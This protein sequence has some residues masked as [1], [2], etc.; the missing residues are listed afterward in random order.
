M[1]YP[2]QAFVLT[3]DG[4]ICVGNAHI[5]RVFSVAEGGELRTESICNRRTETPIELAFQPCSE[6]FVIRIL[7][8][9]KKTA[10]LKASMLTVSDILSTETDG[11]KILE[12]RFAPLH[13][14]GVT[15]LVSECIEVRES[16]PFLYKYLKISASDAQVVIDSIDTEHISLPRNLQQ[17]W[18]RPD[19][20]KA[21][22]SPF[23]AALGQPIYLNGMYTGSEFPAND[24]NIE[25]GIAHVRYYAGKTLS[26]LAKG[27]KEYVTWKT[28]FGAARGLE[29]EVIRA[30]FLDYIRSISRPLYLR[31]QYNS[32]FDHMLDIDKDNIRNSFFEIEKG[33]TQNGVPPVHSYV[34]DDGW[35][36]YDKDFWCFNKKFPNELYESAALAKNFSS[37]FGLWLGP[38]GGY[39]PK[40]PKF[41][42]RM[43]K[44]GKGGCNRRSRDVCT[45][46]HDY[47][48]NITELFLDYMERFDINYWKLDGF[49]LKSC[50]SKHHGHPTGGY[51]GM[52]C[53]TDHWEHWIGIFQKMRDAR[54]AMGKSL[55][56]N[57]T[58]F[59]NA[60]PW[61]LQFCESLWMQNS[62]DIDFVDKTKSGEPMHG[63]D[64]DK[65]LT[66]RDGRYFDFHRTRA[67]QFPL[68]NMYNH[69]PIYGNTA[70]ISMTDDEYRQY[71]YMIATRGTAFW[72]LYYSFSLFN[73][74]KWQINADVLKF[75]AKNFHILRNARL[76]GESP[77]TGAV[78]GY[79]GW[80]GAEGI[81]SVRNPLDRPQNFSFVLDRCIG[82][83]EGASALTCAVILPYTAGLDPKAYAYGDTVTVDLQPHEIRIFKFGMA[84]THAP[85]IIRAKMLNATTAQV[86]FDKRIAVKENSF[87]VNDIALSAELLPN[88]SEVRVSLQKPLT[89]GEEIKLTA[90][91]SD[92]YGNEMTETVMLLYHE[93]GKMA[94]VYTGNSDFTLRIKLIDAPQDGILFTQGKD[95]VVSVSNGKLI[96]DCMGV[97]AK[98]DQALR[99]HSAVRADIVRERNGMVKVYVDGTLT[100]SGYD[101]KRI[102]APLAAEDVQTGAAVHEFA[103]FDTALAFDALK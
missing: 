77:E 47:Q 1:K 61:Y 45:A 83:D 34:V 82:V 62:G 69:E 70:N 27:A 8:G 98:S 56:L 71:M 95:L 92:I 16:D 18:S 79:S 19:M 72:E 44:A 31:T 58:S 42:K 65:M 91:V 102:C 39:N 87:T 26:E 41:A 99:T 55:W 101:A 78:Y 59:C 49:L 88:Y 74:A 60:S 37:D 35:P 32:W 7:V 30:D 46:D 24:N 43:Q 4:K 64:F 33:L 67:Y 23:Q 28:V 85:K 15:Y 38:R 29:Q 17:K 36:D 53:F 5:V 97:K 2:D 93:N 20:K 3:G 89:N 94:G 51:E 54:S 48:K 80:D 22:L 40:T 81:V 73:E 96:A 21:F 68:S 90:A 103:Y 10:V 11:K 86:T 12:I 25:N 14:L 75:V 63:K 9:R 66:H 76:I 6:E 57:Q 52:Y 100:G 50:P 84:E 13:A